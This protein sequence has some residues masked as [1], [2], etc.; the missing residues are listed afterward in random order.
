MQHTGKAILDVK[1]SSNWVRSAAS[2]GINHSIAARDRRANNFA[3]HQISTREIYVG[4]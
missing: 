3:Q 2:R 1:K 4:S